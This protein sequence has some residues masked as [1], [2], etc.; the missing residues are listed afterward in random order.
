MK[1]DKAYLKC[2]EQLEASNDISNDGL[3]TMRVYR[4]LENLMR[5]IGH[6]ETLEEQVAAS[7]FCLEWMRDFICN[8][9]G[10]QLK[11]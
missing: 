10:V 11:D 3:S 7:V 5:A 4:Q 2:I 9:I 6:Y 8:K 1:M